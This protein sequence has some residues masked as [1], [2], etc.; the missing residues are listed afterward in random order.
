MYLSIIVPCHREGLYLESC[1]QSVFN[2]IW[3]PD[4]W[5][6]II[7]KDD[8]DT[9]TENVIESLQFRQEI[10]IVQNDIGRGSAISRNIGVSTASGN[11]VLFLDGDDELT[12]NSIQIRCDIL[13]KNY[14]FDWFFGDFSLIDEEGVVI[15]R[16]WYKSR[17]IFP[18][19]YFESYETNQIYCLNRNIH[20]FFLGGLPWTG[21]IMAKKTSLLEIG[22]F[23]P[24]LLQAQDIHLWFRLGLYFNGCFIPKLLCR[25]R[26]RQKSVTKCR[27][28]PYYWGRKAYQKLLNED[29][30]KDYNILLQDEILNL[31]GSDMWFCR[32]NNMWKD[33]FCICLEII[34]R[35]PNRAK[36]W[37]YLFGTIYRYL[38]S[39][40]FSHE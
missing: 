20:S 25:Y 1:V 27:K 7:I 5:E 19:P 10:L 28:M 23:D 24:D 4:K 22:G 6:I 9:I 17:N 18:H 15:E 2:Q 33:A 26:D 14:N 32:M 11:W 36:H 3:M 39:L 31:L 30:F 37:R 21:T 34:K 29:N 8:I 16:S 38:T 13:K 12:N 40:R 35:S